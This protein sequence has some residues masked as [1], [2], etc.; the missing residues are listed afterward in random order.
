MVSLLR[1]S[2]KAM[3]PRVAFLAS[4]R[5]GAFGMPRPGVRELPFQNHFQGEAMYPCPYC[6][7]AAILVSTYILEEGAARIT[8][9]LAT[10]DTSTPA[11][12]HEK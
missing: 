12:P 4:I 6:H 5:L 7:G 11:V 9:C 8:M 2:A 10:D 1:L 3:A